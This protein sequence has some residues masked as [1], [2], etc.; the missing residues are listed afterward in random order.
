MSSIFTLRVKRGEKKTWCGNC[1][2][3]WP[4]PYLHSSQFHFLG[5]R[6]NRGSSPRGSSPLLL[7]YHKD[8][9][10]FSKM[11]VQV[12]N[13]L[14]DPNILNLRDRNRLMQ[15]FFGYQFCTCFGKLDYRFQINKSQCFGGTGNSVPCG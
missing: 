15:A 6:E 9:I 11:Q 4:L 3:G 12:I 14:F 1:F 7:M 8:T 10:F 2:I 13:N 5:D